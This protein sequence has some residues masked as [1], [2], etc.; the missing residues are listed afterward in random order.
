MD[1][2][3]RMRC[4]V[5]VAELR[6]FSAAARELGLGQPTASKAVAALEEQLGTRLLQRTTRSLRLTDE[7]AR[8]HATC[9]RV[10]A[11]LDEAE[12]SLATSGREPSG[13]LRVSAAR[14]LGQ[15]LLAPALRTYLESHPRVEI[16]LV[17]DERRLDLTTEGIDVAVRLGVLA[18]S[19]LV[20]RRLGTFERVTAAAPAYL[21]RHGE[22]SRPEDLAGHECLVMTGL[23]EPFRWVWHDAKGRS[24]SVQ[25]SGRLRANSNLVMRDAALAGFGVIVAPRWL[26][27]GDLEDGRLRAVLTAFESPRMPVHALYRGG[28]LVPLKVR[29]FVD[30]LHDAWRPSALG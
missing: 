26:V 9:L 24:R 25:V 28:P 18:D 16:D 4:F 27:Q 2:L 23:S 22:P 6:S 17:L 8:Y 21:E 14:E 10:L 7:G 3:D 20:A 29:S 11:E 13:T 19:S 1:R 30:F 5:R 12:S 15:I